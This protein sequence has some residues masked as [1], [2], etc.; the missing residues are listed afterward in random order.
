MSSH[1]ESEALQV[2]LDLFFE[3]VAFR[4]HFGEFAGEAGHFLLEGFVVLHGVFDADVA[5]G[6][7][8]VVLLCD[9]CGFDY[10]AEAFFVLEFAFLEFFEGA[11]EAFDVQFAE[12]AVLAV[13]HVAHVAGVDEEC[14]AFLLFAAGDE[15]ECHGD[16]HAVEQLGGHGHDAFDKVRLDDA[17]ADFAF[18]AG[19]RAECSVCKHEPDFSIW[20]EVVNHVFNPGEVGVACRREPVL[21]ARVVLQLFL[22]P[23]LE[24]ERRVRHDKIES[25]GGVQVLEECVFVMFAEVRIDAADGHIHLRH[26]PSVG[27]GFLSVNADVVTVA[28]VVLDKL[29][30]LHEHAAGT[31]A[32]VVNA[33]AFARLEDAHDGL[34]DA[35]GGVEFTA[36]HAFVACELCDAVFIG[37]AKQILACLGVAHVHVAEHI[38]HIAEHALV[39]FRGGVV[40]GEDSL[41]VLVVLFDIDHRLVQHLADFGGVGGLGNFRPAGARW[42]K[43]DVFLHVFVWFVFEAFA[44]GDEFVITLFEC[45]GNVA[46]E[47][48]PGKNFAVFCCRDVPPQFA[49]CVPDLLFEPEGRLCRRILFC[50]TCHLLRLF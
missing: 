20:S 12:V 11:C 43:E 10:G 29:D 48:E 6:G 45:G 2:F 8:D 32:G 15:P 30:A 36:L 19:L 17:F 37:A 41:E 40:L 28:A 35:C 42:H 3:V 22:S 25:L 16:G 9:V 44:F 13:H 38:H 21:P 33:F 47:D 46:Q 1:L 24:V 27:V 49:C 14:L 7:E 31:T 34:D 50:C 4:K 18:A 26:F 23:V 39:K 5:A